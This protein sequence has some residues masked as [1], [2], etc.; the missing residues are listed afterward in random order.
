MT[1]TTSRSPVFI[2]LLS[3]LIA[4]CVTVV[5]TKYDIYVFLKPLTLIC[6]YIVAWQ[7]SVYLVNETGVQREIIELPQ[8]NEK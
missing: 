6:H 4:V 5:C 8:I 7:R 3:W 2:L 1:D